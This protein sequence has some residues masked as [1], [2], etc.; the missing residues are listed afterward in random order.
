[1]IGG[2][3][4]ECVEFPREDPSIIIDADE[5]DASSPI[6]ALEGMKG[7]PE[8]GIGVIHRGQVLAHFDGDAELLPDLSFQATFQV[9]ALFELPPGNSQSPPSKPFGG[10][11]VIRNRSPRQMIPAVTS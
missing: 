7:D 11:R 3:K 6:P 8:V 9:L 2:G 10:R 5:L 4:G 1:M